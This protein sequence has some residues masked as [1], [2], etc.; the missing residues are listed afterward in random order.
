[1]V[2]TK[3][4]ICFAFTNQTKEI[5]RIPLDG[6]DYVKS[7]DES[8]MKTDAELDVARQNCVLQIATDPDG[9]NSGRSY[10]VR[11]SSK[12]T[13]DEIH[14]LLASLARA[15]RKRAN[16]STLF[17]RAQIRVKEMY[18][19]IICQTLVALIIV[20]VSPVR[21]RFVVEMS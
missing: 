12:E 7:L 4:C 11:I 20:G 3:D 17:Q 14:P 8:G 13:Y 1:M 2:I 19:H 5:D 21:S 10:H 18:G 9:H 16:A 15:A 6:V